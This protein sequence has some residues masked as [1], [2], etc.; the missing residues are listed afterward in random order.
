[1][2]SAWCGVNLASRWRRDLAEEGPSHA[3]VAFFLSFD[4]L[5][6]FLTVQA[7]SSLACSLEKRGAGRGQWDFFP[8][9]VTEPW[10]R[11]PREV[12]ESPSL[13][14][15]RSCLDKVLCSLLWVTLLQQAVG[16]GD[17]QRSLP[18]PAMLGFCDSAEGL[19]QSGTGHRPG[20][21]QQVATP[22]GAS[23]S[24][25][26]ESCLRRGLGALYPAWGG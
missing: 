8:L 19:R 6:F 23:P 7:L 11:L 4:Y 13:E 22:W 14:I 3:L 15:F 5:C 16:L 12:V 25:V 17:P 20:S 26:G 21:L 2:F 24:R 9:R 18:T 10:R 1:M